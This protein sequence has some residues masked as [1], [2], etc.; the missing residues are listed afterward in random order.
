MADILKLHENRCSS[1]AKTERR[2][3]M[4]PVLEPETRD[5]GDC[6]PAAMVFYCMQSEFRRENHAVRLEKLI[7]LINGND[8]LQ[9]KTAE[10]KRIYLEEGGLY[11]GC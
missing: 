7:R 5:S 1:V 8:R 3:H 11:L 9:S 2:K 6:L 10:S 4:S